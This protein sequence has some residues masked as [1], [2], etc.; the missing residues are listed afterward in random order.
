MTFSSLAPLK[1]LSRIGALWVVGL[2]AVVMIFTI[3]GNVYPVWQLGYEDCDTASTGS[4]N[5]YIYLS[6]KDGLC[7]DK[8]KSVTDNFAECTQWKEIDVNDDEAEK[9]ADTYTDAYGL[10]TT[11]L[12]LACCFV[13]MSLVVYALGAQF[14]GSM[15]WRYIQIF[16]CVLIMALSGAASGSISDTFYTDDENYPY[17][18][19]CE[20]SF[21]TPVSGWAFIFF[22]VWITGAALAILLFPCGKCI[23]NEEEEMLNVAPKDGFN[24]VKSRS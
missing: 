11:S 21:T 18:D 13:V 19:V 14:K 5:I 9:D 17:I 3:L 10:S 12:V 1:P 20:D 23:Y 22:T 24:M 6:L 4:D 15:V 2:A 7:E 8:D 16:V